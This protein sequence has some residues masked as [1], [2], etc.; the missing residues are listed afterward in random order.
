MSAITE[1]RSSGTASLI[2]SNRLLFGELK[3]QTSIA[4]ATRTTLSRGIVA[5]TSTMVSGF[6]S[7]LQGISVG[8]I[9]L[10]RSMSLQAD[11]VNIYNNLIEF[12]GRL[13]KFIDPDVQVEGMELLSGQLKEKVSLVQR[14][15]ETWENFLVKAVTGFLQLSYTISQAF[16]SIRPNLVYVHDRLSLLKTEFGVLGGVF[17]VLKSGLSQAAVGL[18]K[19]SVFVTKLGGKQ[20]IKGA[21][22]AGNMFKDMGKASV[23][24]W[25]MEQIMKLFKPFML[26][27]K[28]FEPLFTVLGSILAEMLIPVMQEMM[29]WIM[30]AVDWLLKVKEAVKSFGGA[31]GLLGGIFKWIEDVL[32]GHSLVPA[33][34]LFYGILKLIADFYESTF[35]FVWE[36]VIKYFTTIGEVVGKALGVL[37]NFIG[38][39]RDIV[40]LAGGGSSRSGSSN[41]IGDFFEGIGSALGFAGG[42]YINSPSYIKV[43][44]EE[45]EFVF[46]KTQTRAL[47]GLGI[48]TGA[49]SV[50]M[51]MLLE[52]IDRNTQ[53]SMEWL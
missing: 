24:A 18:A 26:L 11:F 19:V 35:K 13:T 2:D 5:L 8:F 1:E 43:A 15:E 34:N 51:E 41:P 30:I 52:N 32:V 46:T 6:S 40:A 10:I 28:P 17:H 12:F 14:I 4:Q 25:A 45:G 36:G 21:K 20:L 3:K 42:G 7:L 50:Y 49:G 22:A 29:P 31:M 27:L 37:D 38:L 23:Q 16:H 48:D 33:F 53:P 39:V 47:A 44:E 9:E